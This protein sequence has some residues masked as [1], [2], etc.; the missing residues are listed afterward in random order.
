MGKLCI[1]EISRP[2]GSDVQ[3][4]L[5]LEWRPHE[6]AIT[7]LNLFIFDEEPDRQAELWTSSADQSVQLHY[8][9][10]TFA[11][12]A[13]PSLR[14]RIPHDDVVRCAWPDFEEQLL[15][16]GAADEVIRVWDLEVLLKSPAPKKKGWTEDKDTSLLNQALVS[17]VDEHFHDVHL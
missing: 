15:F 10:P 16:T 6:T 13:E 2:G 1:W 11:S 3:H 14:L 17:E 8:F 5:L 7:S 4:S 9:D 12:R